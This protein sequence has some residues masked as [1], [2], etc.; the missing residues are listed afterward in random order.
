M[1][2][3][4]EPIEVILARRWAEFQQRRLSWIGRFFACVKGEK[5]VT[6][7]SL[8]FLLCLGITLNLFIIA[9]PGYYSH[10][11]LVRGV[12][13]SQFSPLEAW[14]PLDFSAFQYRPI[15][16][17]MEALVYYLFA[18]VPPLAHLCSVL[19]GVIN[20]IL[21]YHLLLRFSG[22]TR[23]AFFGFVSFNLFPASVFVAGWLAAAPDLYW[24]TA[25]LG[26]AHLLLSDR[27]SARRHGNSIFSEEW[28]KLTP[29]QV[30]R[31]AGIAL[32]FVLALMS[33]ETSL[34]MPAAIAGVCML[35]KPWR[36]WWWAIAITGFIA[37][38]YL[39]LRW[40]GILSVPQGVGI[41]DASLLSAARN[42]A[43]Y[44]LYPWSSGIVLD[45]H[46]RMDL[47]LRLLFSRSGL[48]YLAV[49]A[50]LFP[51]LLLMIRRSW[52]W[53]MAYVFYYYIF[54]MPVL[55]VYS[56]LHFLY[57]AVLPVSA[58][59]SY[60]L[61]RGQPRRVIAAALVFL[62][63]LAVGGIRRSFCFYSTGAYQNRLHQEIFNIVR[64]HD[65]LKGNN[66]TTFSV[67]SEEEDFGGSCITPFSRFR[68]LHLNIAP[69]LNNRK[70]GGYEFPS[71]AFANY[72][73][74]IFDYHVPAEREK[75]PADAVELFDTEEGHVIER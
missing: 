40:G 13:Y 70:T 27:N 34:V 53:A 42:A 33:K 3:K 36:G 75:T 32:L 54:I 15:S 5:G 52:R 37:A 38:L 74:R 71:A 73:H 55:M 60:S 48:L 61:R 19:H 23:A 7:H 56:D 49:A 14:N 25:A 57:G 8:L 10:E 18:G 11:D 45:L 20:S 62:M 24:M 69:L 41:Y 39:L 43:G 46:L 17:F 4:L 64:T 28:W 6:G 50:L 1:E 9:S 47:F 26:I 16:E 65:R 58:M 44:W 31:Q 30:W 59:F 2:S 29:P 63:L 66:Q 72:K 67:R 22:Q 51:V 35:V 12:R 21:F 68:A